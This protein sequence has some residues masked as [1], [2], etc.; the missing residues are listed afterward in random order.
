MATLLVVLQVLSSALADESSI[1]LVTGATGRTGSLIYK[2]LV[3]AGFNTRAL[4][5]SAE[6]AAEVLN[7]TVCD[8]SEGIFIGDVT[9][10][11]SL[12]PAMDGVSFVA[13]AVGVSGSSTTQVMQVCSDAK[14]TSNNPAPC[15][16]PRVCVCRLFKD[17][18]WHGVENQVSVLA[19]GATASGRPLSSLGVALISSM[20][21]T[22]PNP[23]A[24]AVLFRCI[25]RVS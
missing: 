18:E 21:T 3:A 7:C 17:V 16:L 2:Q 19:S 5:T 25:L 10:S 13:I 14:T 1:Y 24:F 20:G 9:N 23:P 22:N 8:A 4:A 6:T 12:L 11:S 15:L